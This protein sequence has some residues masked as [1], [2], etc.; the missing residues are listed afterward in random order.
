[1]QGKGCAVHYTWANG[2]QHNEAAWRA[3]AP[4]AVALFE[5]L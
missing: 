3:R 2:A 4:A 5:S 1:M